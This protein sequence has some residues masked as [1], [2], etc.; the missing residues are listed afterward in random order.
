MEKKA[1]ID[2]VF[3]NRQN[4]GIFKVTSSRYANETDKTTQNSRNKRLKQKFATC[5]YK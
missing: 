4:Q 2:I 3:G 1:Q 5:P